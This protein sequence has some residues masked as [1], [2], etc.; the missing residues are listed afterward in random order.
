[1]EKVYV[2]GVGQT[3]FG[4]Q[5]QFSAR[6]LAIDAILRAVRDAGIGLRDLQMAYAGNY[7]DPISTT[8]CQDIFS[9][10][11]VSRIPMYNVLNACATGISELDLLYS[12]IALG[13]CEVGIAVGTDS[14]TTSASLP[15]GKLL[16]PTDLIGQL[17]WSVSSC[18]AM[19]ANRFI[20]E[21]GATIED[22]CYPAV[23]NHRNACGNE[24]AMFRREVSVEEIMA[25][26]MISYP[27]TVKQCCP[28]TDGAAA[29]ILCSEKFARKHTT[30]MI[31][32]RGSV[33][34]SGEFISVEK[35]ILHQSI[36]T[37]ACEKL[38]EQTGIGMDEVQ[39]VESHD[40]F[41]PEELQTYESMLLCKRGEG[42]A[43]MREGWF[44]IGGR[45]AVNA[46]GGLE[47]LGH[48]IAASG[49][50]VVAEVAL[51]LRG[52]A[53]GH[54]VENARVGVAQMVGG[55]L[56]SLGAPVASGLQMLVRQ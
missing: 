12:N 24:Y 41:S 33:L 35:D 18:L 8:P 32:V 56:T 14:M 16:A 1:M 37:E 3:M 27:I 55:T 45:C 39:C 53:K 11:G 6:D 31:E 23:K 26:P 50:R 38:Q 47:A 4:K 29:V 51:Q 44:D 46:S 13:R 48:P 7:A 30:R 42:I 43:R 40:A 10:L 36:L 28:F 21:Q 22:I 2:L 54:Q 5:P 49:V 19:V 34:L 9:R 20:A 15:K 17:G 52:E 25:S